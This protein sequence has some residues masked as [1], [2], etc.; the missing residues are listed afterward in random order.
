MS[1]LDTHGRALESLRVSVTDRCNLRCSYCMPEPDYVWL[2]K[3]ELLSFEEIARLVRV[4]TQLGVR[5]VRL[6]G[7]EPLLRAELPTLVEML[8]KIPGIEDL[9]LTTNGILL[10]DQA[11]KLKS[12]GLHRVTVSLDTLD[13]DR[14]AK[15]TRRTVHGDVLRGIDAASNAGLKTL[16]LD[17]VLLRG[18]NDDEIAPLL[19]FARAHQAELRFIEYMDVG[20][21]TQWSADQVVSKREILDQLTRI[22]GAPKALPRHDVA[23]ADRFALP[24]GL[25]FGII[26][27][28]TEPFCATCDRAR[29]TADGS[30]YLCLY[31]GKGHDL[32]TL[33]R[34]GASDESI[35]RTVSAIWSARNDRGAEQRHALDERVPLVRIGELRADP[36][37]EMHTRGG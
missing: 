17:T 37:L 28:V 32:R 4:F 15:L 29:V 23:P 6:T 3:D 10:A 2:P 11:T 22:Y 16:K 27:S 34:S 1:V 7:G 14:F 36:R 8:A 33:L 25:T 20:G 12:A 18:L 9:A 5:R 19:E 35:A 26:A 13:P 31:A 21:A 24:D 30:W